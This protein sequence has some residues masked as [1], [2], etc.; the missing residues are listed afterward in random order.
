MEVM[1]RKRQIESANV[2][3]LVA[4]PACALFDVYISYA[5][6]HTQFFLHFSCTVNVYQFCKFLVV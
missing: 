5:T 1:S 4:L 6:I 2:K 3:L